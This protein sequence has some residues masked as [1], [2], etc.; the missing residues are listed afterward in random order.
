MMGRDVSLKPRLT[1]DGPVYDCAVFELD[2]DRL[3][4]ELHQES[5]LG[6]STCPLEIHRQSSPPDEL[7]VEDGVE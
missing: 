3:V 4:V 1:G 5:T 7:H 2:R 6:V